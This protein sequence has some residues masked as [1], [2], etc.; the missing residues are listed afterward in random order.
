MPLWIENGILQLFNEENIA[1]TVDILKQNVGTIQNF[2]TKQVAAITNGGLSV[3]ST[4]GSMFTSWM[5][6]GIATFFIILERRSIGR[7]FLEI[8]PDNLEAYFRHIY[9][10][11]QVVCVSWV[12]A[13]AM[14]GFSIFLFTY[15]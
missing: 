5:F 6:I 1:D 3:L 8:T 13:T 11:I 9:R 15:I 7:V 2:L 12:R 10:E 14:L 4:I